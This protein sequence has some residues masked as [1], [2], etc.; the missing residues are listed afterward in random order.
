M[1]SAWLAQV[2]SP[3]IPDGWLRSPAPATN[4]SP[5][6]DLGGVPGGDPVCAAADAPDDEPNV[7]STD[8]RSN[9]G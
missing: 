5:A 8:Q 4:R 7:K 6:G 1:P 9:R 2:C 3:L